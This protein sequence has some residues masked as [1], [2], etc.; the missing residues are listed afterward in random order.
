[1]SV[2]YEIE[3][4]ELFYYFVESEKN[5]EK[6][7]LLLWLDGGPGCSGFSSITYQFGK[8][9]HDHGKNKAKPLKMIRV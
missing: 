9:Q 3:K 2:E 1:M 4:A 8:Y 6:D 7:P 5:P